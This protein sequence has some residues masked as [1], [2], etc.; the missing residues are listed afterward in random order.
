MIDPLS[1]LAILHGTDKFG[2][3]GSDAGECRILR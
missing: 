3:Q 2:Y 1:R